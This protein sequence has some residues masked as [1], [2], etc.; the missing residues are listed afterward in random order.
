MRARIFA[1]AVAITS[2]ALMTFGAVPA[3]A[4]TVDTGAESG[5]FARINRER[6]SRG[7]ASMAYASDL[8]AVAR[9]HSADMARQGRLYHTPNLGSQVCCW[10]S[11]GE[12]VGEG[13]SVDSVH[14][15]FMSSA[16]HRD[17]IL[18]LAF[19]QVGVGVVSSGGT[20][21]VTEIFRQPMGGAAAP[22]PARAGSPRPA[23]APGPATPSRPASVAAN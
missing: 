19:T 18:S 20:L 2:A 5:F 7:L 11:L 8:V 22:A 4:A 23:A 16:T 15:S 13:A 6:N 17:H 9:R 1:A 12:N 21:W 10:Q 14:N 3:H